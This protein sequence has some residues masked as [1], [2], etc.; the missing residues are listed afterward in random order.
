ME[1][2]LILTTE[3]GKKTRADVLE[4]GRGNRQAKKAPGGAAGPNSLMCHKFIVTS[5]EYTGGY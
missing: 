2:R 1:K 4:P 3:G 5:M